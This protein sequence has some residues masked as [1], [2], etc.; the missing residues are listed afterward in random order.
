MRTIPPQIGTRIRIGRKLYNIEEE[1]SP[2]SCAGCCFSNHWEKQLAEADGA[3]CCVTKRYDLT[4]DDGYIYKR[5]DPLYQDLLT[6]K[7]LS[8]E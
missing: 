8:D 5:I 7:E 6:V 2:G 1:E 4:C 3:E